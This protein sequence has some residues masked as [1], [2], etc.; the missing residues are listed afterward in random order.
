ML[1]TIKFPMDIPDIQRCIPH[2]YPFLLI[3]RIIEY[4]K[5][6][7]IVALKNISFT[8][9]H[10]QGHFPDRPVM[11][12]V[13]Q[14]EAMAQASAVYGRLESPDTKNCLLT[15]VTSARFRRL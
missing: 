14:I 15:E 11:P 13:L 9:P 4:R 7:G 10:L 6:E 3:D 8:D 5:G 1:D 12:G 2:R